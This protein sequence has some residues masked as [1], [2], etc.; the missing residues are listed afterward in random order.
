MISFVRAIITDPVLVFMDSPINS[1]DMRSAGRMLNWIKHFKK[2]SKTLVLSST[3]FDDLASMADFI[4]LIS[5]GEMVATGSPEELKSSSDKQITKILGLYDDT[6][7]K[8]EFSTRS[9]HN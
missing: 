5:H 6:D 8:Q 1:V 2:S 9:L 3:N 4:V 7:N